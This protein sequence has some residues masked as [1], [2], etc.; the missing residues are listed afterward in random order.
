MS[1]PAL[2]RPRRPPGRRLSDVLADLADDPA[3][4]SISVADVRD[5]M[6]DRAFGALLILLAVPNALPVNPPGVS[7][8][9]G[10]PI[11]FL[12]VQ[13]VLGF[14]APWLPAFLKQRSM[15]RDGFARAMDV[16]VPWLRRVERLLKPRLSMLAGRPAE[17]VIGLVCLLLALVLAMPIPFGNMP[18]A[19]AICVLALAM[20]EKDGLAVLAGLAVATGALLVGGGVLLGLLKAVSLFLRHLLGA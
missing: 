9:L 7:T 15:A 1:V 4:E 10:V 14:K 6:G 16:A 17:R 2:H 3:R 11:M 19:V 20:L 12:A 8:V 18:P 13:M 5:A